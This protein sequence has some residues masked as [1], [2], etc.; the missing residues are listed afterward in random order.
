MTE[1]SPQRR[2][3]LI[4]EPVDKGSTIT[5]K[6]VQSAI[7]DFLQGEPAKYAKV[8]V[9]IKP[10]GQLHFMQSA[11]TMSMVV[12]PSSELSRKSAADAVIR[13][14]FGILVPHEVWV[15][16]ESL[17]NTCGYLGVAHDLVF[18]HKLHK[19]CDD[20][21]MSVEQAMDVLRRHLRTLKVP[22]SVLAGC[23]PIAQQDESTPGE[24]RVF[25]YTH[26]LDPLQSSRVA[27]FLGA[28]KPALEDL[29][30]GKFTIRL[31]INNL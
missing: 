22:S 15:M 23:E 11:L 30:A 12:D 6:A 28:V 26:S 21:C 31:L 18:A 3:R 7:L 19:L 2:L 24:F 13:Q 1:L 20:D 27:S 29:P 10:T 14:L 16:S 4:C 17:M 9:A 8:T 25:E 5:Y